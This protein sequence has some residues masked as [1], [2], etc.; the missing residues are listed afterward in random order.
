MS[1]GAPN[2]VDI[3][4]IARQANIRASDAKSTYLYEDPEVRRHRLDQAAKDAHQRRIKDAVL[5]GVAILG[6]VILAGICVYFILTT[7]PEDKRWAFATPI[8]ASMFT[9]FIGYL[10]G[11]KAS[12]GG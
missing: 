3:E 9:G 7:A 2:S 8:L 11:S 1:A 4:E 6:A 5:F 12:G 10:T